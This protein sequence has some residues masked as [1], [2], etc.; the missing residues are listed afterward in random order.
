[1]ALS[2]NLIDPCDGVLILKDSTGKPI[3]LTI[4]FTSFSLSDLI[5]DQSTSTPGPDLR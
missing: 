1:M 2:P 5:K 4:D 3:V